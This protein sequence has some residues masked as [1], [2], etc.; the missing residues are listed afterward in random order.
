MALLS[1]FKFQ[2][3]MATLELF[4]LESSV[5]RLASLFSSHM[6]R[7]ISGNSAHGQK[8]ENPPGLCFLTAS[9][10]SHVFN[11]KGLDLIS[12]IN[13]RNSRKKSLK[14]IVHP[15]ENTI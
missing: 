3:K 11:M 8:Q 9:L 15:T 7:T 2:M 12:S 10:T 1:L 4:S 6:L 5:T 14:Y 13:K